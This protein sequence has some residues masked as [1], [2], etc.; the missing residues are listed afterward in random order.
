MLH[1]GCQTPWGFFQPIH[2]RSYL[3]PTWMRYQQPCNREGGF[4]KLLELAVQLLVV[5]IELLQR[6]IAI[7]QITI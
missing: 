1:I 3:G 5:F 7:D 4:F 2:Q 6:F